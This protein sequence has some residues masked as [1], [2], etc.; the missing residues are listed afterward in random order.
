MKTPG[1][2][3]TIQRQIILEELRKLCSHPTADELYMVVRQRLPRISLG[4]VYRTLELLHSARMVQK[5]DGPG[6]QKRWDGDTT[7]HF[8]ALCLHCHSILDLPS[9]TVREDAISFPEVKGFTFLGYRVIF[10]G[11]CHSCLSKLSSP[12]EKGGGES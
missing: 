12:A 3:S 2:R 10:E 9:G 4:T 5:L 8:H 11:H 6:T 1:T 7:P